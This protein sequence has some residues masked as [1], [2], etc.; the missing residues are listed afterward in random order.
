MLV[1]EP[2]NGQ[3]PYAAAK[4]LQRFALRTGP[5]SHPRYYASSTTPW[6]DFHHADVFLYSCDG[7]YY[8]CDS[9]K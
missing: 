4:L 5:E 2:A 9:K 1:T 6:K 3:H 7:N 8:N